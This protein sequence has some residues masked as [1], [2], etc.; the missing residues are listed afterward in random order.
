MWPFPTRGHRRT[1][2]ER[3]QQRLLMIN[4]LIDIMV[5]YLF[6]TQYSVLMKFFDV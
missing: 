4:Q 3:K 6:Q 2:Y 5:K 1:S